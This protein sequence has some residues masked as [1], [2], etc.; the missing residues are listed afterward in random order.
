MFFL[1]ECFLYKPTAPPP[2]KKIIL[3][4]GIKAAG[5][6][7]LAC[8]LYTSLNRWYLGTSHI[9]CVVASQGQGNVT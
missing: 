1:T 8:G 2:S 9:F 5:D 4:S 7:Y 6:E 3:L